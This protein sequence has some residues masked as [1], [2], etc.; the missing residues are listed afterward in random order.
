MVKDQAA[1]LRELANKIKSARRASRK[2]GTTRRI[3]IT[4]GK[5][6]VGK[7]SMSLSMG[8]ILARMRKR[9]LLID[10]DINLGN[11]DILMGV[12]PKYM[13]RDVISGEI[14]IDELILEGPE[15]INIIPASSGDVEFL[16]KNDFIKYKIEKELEDIELKYDYVI[17]DT[18][19]GIGNEV[20]DF[21]LNSDEVVIIT[22]SEP[23]AFTDAYAMIKT[24]TAEQPDTNLHVI[25]NMV[26]SPEEGVEVFKKIEMVSNHFLQVDLNYLGHIERD[27]SV[28]KAIQRQV[29][30]FIN[31]DK[32]PASKNLWTATMKLISKANENLKKRKGDVERGSVL[33]DRNKDY[34]L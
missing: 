1:K 22:T 34:D 2:D 16:R 18:G 9:V 11:L 26:D 28:V 3:A 23:T 14:T 21:C 27:V 13:L 4:S 31:N 15:G 5:G 30:F 24:L 33:K 19:A 12:S 8:L 29:P 10:A 17:V 25:V 32:S 6:G 7:S 20:V